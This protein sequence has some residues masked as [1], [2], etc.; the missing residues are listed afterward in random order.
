[1]DLLHAD[2]GCLDAAAALLGR[3]DVR[4]ANLETPLLDE[5]RPLYSTGVRLKSPPG[6]VGILR[7]LGID[8]VSLANNHMMD[9][10]P[11]GLAATLHHLAS[12]GLP[13]VGAGPTRAAARAPVVLTVKG[14]RVAFLAACDNEGGGATRGGPGVSLIAPRALIAAVR[15]AR[16]A[17]EY[18]VVAVHTGI[19]FCP[20]P[21]PFFVKLARRLI[22][23][24]A[25]VV[26]GHHPHVPQGFERY[27]DGLIAYSLGD[28]L[29]DL[30]RD[31]ADMTPHQRRFYGNHPL[32][33]VELAEGRVAAHRIHWL[34]R[35]PDGRYAFPA[36]AQRAALEADHE[37]LCALLADA[38][39]LRRHMGGVYRDLLRGFVYYAPLSFCREFARGGSPQLRAFLWW[40]STLQRGPKRRWLKEGF[41]SLLAWGLARMRGERIALCP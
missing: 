29:F 27:R 32:L 2:P 1:V 35:G 20:C 33:E 21:E 22:E 4:F 14:Q 38:S 28:F 12:E 11:P 41:A 30:P 7:R 8:V 13:A 6:A 19:E 9:F 40:L 36:A 31:P 3:A 37:R 18:V 25:V 39:G 26:A 17:A 23:A 34:T 16:A 24:G 10:G 5:G 15:R